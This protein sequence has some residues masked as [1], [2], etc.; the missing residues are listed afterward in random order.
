MESGRT[1]EENLETKELSSMDAVPLNLKLKKIVKSQ[2]KNV[3][4]PLV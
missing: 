2:P 4:L 3:F 1:R